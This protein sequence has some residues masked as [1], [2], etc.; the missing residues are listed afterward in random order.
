MKENIYSLII[1]L[2]LL[3]ITESPN[4]E[5]L[6]DLERPWHTEYCDNVVFLLIGVYDN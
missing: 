2:G 5:K 4:L 3:L 1:A 6:A